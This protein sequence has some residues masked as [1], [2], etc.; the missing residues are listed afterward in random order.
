MVA[1]YSSKKKRNI[2][3]N[4]SSLCYIYIMKVKKFKEILDLMEGHNCDADMCSLMSDE[5]AE[6]FLGAKS[7]L[8]ELL[9]YSR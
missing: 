8:E 4:N 9:A 5:W 6:H 7:H 1:P 3:D 2:L